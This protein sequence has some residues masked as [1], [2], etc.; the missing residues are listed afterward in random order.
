MSVF[1]VGCGGVGSHLA[2]PLCQL[3][4]REQVVLVDGDTIEK[5]NLN[6]QCFSSADIGKKK[7]DALAER[8]GCG[9]IPDW[10]SFGDRP[11]DEHDC[12][13]CVVDNH[14]ARAAVLQTCDYNR[15]RAIFGANETHSSE[16]Y[17]YHPS[18]LNT[19]L[20]P[21]VYIPEIL[22]NVLGDPRAASIGC[23]GEVQEQNR[24]LVSANVMAASLV[25]HMFVVWEMEA[26]KLPQEAREHLPH[27]L[28]QNLSRNES[29]KAQ[30]TQP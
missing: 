15:C 6:R 16:S 20:D 25:L 11:Y 9:S 19:N 21:R 4:G 18:W 29:F 17:Y 27:R 13:A 1:I 30:I 5:K 14:P 3:I 8:Y 26:R 7:S 22:T 10:F 23:T 2:G 12:I 28:I 24:Q